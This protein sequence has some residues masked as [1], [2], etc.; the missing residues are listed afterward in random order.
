MKQQRG[1]CVRACVC[2]CVYACMCACM[3][4][5][6]CGSSGMEIFYVG[7]WKVNDKGW[8]PVCDPHLGNISRCKCPKHF[9][10]LRLILSQNA[11]FMSSVGGERGG[12][13]GGLLQ[14]LNCKFKELQSLLHLLFSQLK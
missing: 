14:D 3:R 13:G 9:V 11:K 4:V 7:V 1:L 12:G 5:C 6:V 2:L 10:Q 8:N